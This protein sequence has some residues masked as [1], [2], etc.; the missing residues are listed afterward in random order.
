MAWKLYALPPKKSNYWSNSTEPHSKK[1]S[2]Y[3]TPQQMLPAMFLGIL[4][5]EATCKVTTS[6]PFGSIIRQVGVVERE[7]AIQ[8][9]TMNSDDSCSWCI[10]IN[11]FIQRDDLPNAVSQICNPHEK[12]QW[13]K[14]VNKAV[15]YKWQH[16]L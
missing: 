16:D 14:Q 2:I 7:V 9:M 6:N 4:P 5:I 3:K 15:T 12:E 8:Q 1:S 11:P 10:Y 13:K